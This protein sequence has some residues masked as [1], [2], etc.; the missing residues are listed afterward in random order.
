MKKLKYL[1]LTVILLF[2]CLGLTAFAEGSAATISEDYQTLCIGGS[3]YSRFNT[4]MID[5]D[6]FVV[7]I[8]VE[9]TASQ[10]E[11]IDK[12][13][14]LMTEDSIIAYADI[15]FKDGANLYAGFLRD[16]YLKIF[17]E[18]SSSEDGEYL[19]DFQYPEDNTV[20]VEK[21]KLFGNPVVLGSEE[22]GW[23]DY[24]SVIMKS[25]VG[26]LCVYKGSIIVIDEDCYYVDYEEVGVKSWYEFDPYECDELPAYEIS[27][28]ELIAS[29]REGESEYYADDFGFFYDDNFTE[30]LSAVFLIFVFAIIPFV[31]LVVFLIL[32]IRS[33]TVYRKMFAA[34]SILSGAELVVFAV[35]TAVIMMYR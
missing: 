1:I 14:F 6:C 29:I 20:P 17:T 23:C 35:I 31:I 4:S 9:L 33:K 26:N 24:Y 11:I 34:I 25:S 13:E 19:I 10:Q 22:L 21:S 28:E 15:Y 5:A 12:V 27:D 3:T 8:A 16:D 7:D 2:S 32:A 30:K 18:L